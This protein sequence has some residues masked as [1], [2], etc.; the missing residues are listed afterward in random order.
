MDF[1]PILASRASSFSSLS[2]TGTDLKP[3]SHSND[4]TTLVPPSTLIFQGQHIVDEAGG[5]QPLYTF[6]RDVAVVPQKFTS[7]KVAGL[8]TSGQTT[9]YTHLF[10]L[11]HPLGAKYQTERPEYYITCAVSPA[12]AARNADDGREC[13]TLGNIVLDAE[14][15]TSR[16]SSQTAWKAWLSPGTNM[17]SQPLFGNDDN[18]DSARVPLFEAT[19]TK[20]TTIWTITPSPLAPFEAASSSSRGAFSRSAKLP[21][22]IAREDIGTDR[23]DAIARG[24]SSVVGKN[25]IKSYPKLV[26][27]VPLR[28]P[29]RDALV[30]TWILRLW[31]DILESPAAQ[32]AGK[33][34]LFFSSSRRFF[35]CVSTFHSLF[36]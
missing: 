11:A 6:D 26:I 13:P 22:E 29:E 33:L 16:W 12:N 31:R 27:S 10:Y 3:W 8:R 14:A 32:K 25:G 15:T 34:L 5:S 2:S 19:E 1:K 36:C 4:D 28:Q 18:K 17:A 9:Q 30:A 21:G 24:R 7:V 35:F 23:A 20:T